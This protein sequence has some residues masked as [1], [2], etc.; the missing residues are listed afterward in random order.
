LREANPHPSPLFV[1]IS[2]AGAAG[3]RMK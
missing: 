3:R 2:G 1:G